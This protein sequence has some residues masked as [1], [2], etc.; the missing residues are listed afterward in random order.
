MRP[1]LATARAFA[2]VIAAMLLIV[3]GAGIAAA[4]TEYKGTYQ[5]EA[6]IW[7]V[8]AAPALSVTDPDDPNIALIQTAA[9]QQAE[10]LKQLLQTRSFL[11]DV[12]GRTSL[13]ARFAAAADQ[14]GF[15]G[16]IQKRFRVETL[17]TSLIKVSFAGH[18][19]TTPPE[20]LNAA[21]AVRAE[22][23]DQA[24]QLSSAAL[25]L[26]YQRQ[27]EYAQ[28]EALDAQTALDE[29]NRSHPE[30]LSEPDQHVRGQLRLNVDFALVRLSDLRGRQERAALAPAL[31]EV[32]GVEFQIV[33]QP[34][35][36]TRPS[37]GERTAMLIA[38]VALAAGVGL[39][40]LLVLV[41]TLIGGRTRQVVRS[42]APG[43]VRV[44]VVAA[45]STPGK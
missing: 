39:A 34:R 38:F 35:V 28:Q 30:P 44:D 23:I 17:G 36:S 43:R 37:G 12:V 27:L 13:K 29:F 19:P 45:P 31:L 11:I 40:A 32:S 10:V 18:D 15:L 22:R 26:L 21:L 14:D 42:G 9:A 5:S 25:G 6:T 4:V 16:D 1:Y 41:G 33:D 8:R 2:W 7:A 24:R 20:L 3:W